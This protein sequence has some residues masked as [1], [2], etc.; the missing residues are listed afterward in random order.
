MLFGDFAVTSKTYSVRSVHDSLLR[1]FHQ[2]L[3]AQYHIW[4]E[5]LISERDRI[6]KE[7]GNTYQEPRLEATP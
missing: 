6:I 3:Q 5:T 1:T 7:T 4:D 2:Y